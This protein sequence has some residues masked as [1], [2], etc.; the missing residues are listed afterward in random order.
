MRG[1]TRSGFVEKA[2]TREILDPGLT[3]VPPVAR[4]SG[5]SL[6][7]VEGDQVACLAAELHAHQVNRDAK[8]AITWAA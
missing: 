4:S 6:R 8:M 1:M 3:R 2:A 7:D 5:S